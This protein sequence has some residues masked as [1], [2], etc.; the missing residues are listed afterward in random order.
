MKNLIRS[1]NNNSGDYDEKY[2]NLP[3]NKIVEFYDIEIVIRSVSS[4]DN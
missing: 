2:G 3:L 4:Y 1:A